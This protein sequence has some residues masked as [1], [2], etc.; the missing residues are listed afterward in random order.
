MKASTMVTADTKFDFVD[1]CLRSLDGIP[2]NLCNGEYMTAWGD[3]D[4]APVASVR[5]AALRNIAREDPNAIKQYFKHGPFVRMPQQ[6]KGSG[7][8]PHILARY[9]Y[10]ISEDKLYTAEE[11]SYYFEPV[12]KRDVYVIRSVKYS[13]EELKRIAYNRTSKTQYERYSTNGSIDRDLRARLL[14]DHTAMV[15]FNVNTT[16]I[17]GNSVAFTALGTGAS[18]YVDQPTTVINVLSHFWDRGFPVTIE[19]ISV[20]NIDKNKTYTAEV[21]VVKEVSWNC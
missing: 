21:R 14:A 3:R 18:F 16:A 11:N 6:H 5:A 15:G 1:D 19:D 13:H 10:N 17:A 8:K 9:L 20:Y 7:N 12:L 2:V 4:R